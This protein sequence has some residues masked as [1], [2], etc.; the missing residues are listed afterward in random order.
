MNGRS[1]GS[2]II[3]MCWLVAGCGHSFTPEATRTRDARP[4]ASIYDF[5]VTVPGIS[6]PQFPAVGLTVDLTLEV[7]P[8]SIDASGFF[9][10]SISINEVRA[11]GV[12]RPFTAADPLPA[13]GRVAGA[14]WSV[15][16][17]G[18]IQVGTPAAGMTN[19]MLSL[20]GTLSPDGREIEGAA[21]VTSSGETG[22]FFAVKQR[23]YLVAGTDFGVT[24]TASLVTV[25]FNTS[26][27]VARDLEAISGDPVARA[28][29]G[30]VVVI[31]RFFF[32]NVQTLD[33]A[34]DFQTAL[35][36][37]T[38]NGSNPH[39]VLAV[40]PNRFYVTRYEPPYNDLLIADRAGGQYLG[41]VDLS[42]YA[43]ND[44]ATPRADGM[45]LA[46]NL[47]FVG[48]QNIDSS[49]LEYGPGLVAVVD[50]GTD[51]V[52]R[53]IGMQ[54][55]NPFGPPA[56][57]PETGDLYYAMAGIFEGGLPRDLSGGIEVV[58]PRTLATQG[59]L[60]D[61][62]DLG[63]N[64]SGVALA[65]AGGATRG[66]CIVTTASGANVVRGFDPATGAVSPGTI[67]SPGA[68]V[69]EVVSD[70]DGYLLV[71]VRDP[72]DPRLVVLDAAS[73]QVIASPSL[74]LP[75]FSVAVLTRGFLKGGASAA[76]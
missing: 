50:P 58:D 46:E 69:P 26:I 65:L 37:S 25:R 11:G 16:S 61:D 66:Y 3:L 53:V 74:S 9:E 60:V 24:G 44:S 20:S 13:A 6:F 15:D 8:A 52:V 48:L 21:V 17:F 42:S 75:P 29:G 4:L 19:V 63:G 51:T 76:R 62:D 72:S 12:V 67:L 10:A 73:G 27:I 18:P 2:L 33:P 5:L 40:D 57:H 49:F 47:V 71:P 56:V 30:A 35:Q 31:N 38:G 41:F 1:R 22:T 14:E 43:T 36:F 7:D 54:G 55:R 64:V 28:T 39:D 59:L 45:A 68:F 34:A 32:D 23:R 70:G